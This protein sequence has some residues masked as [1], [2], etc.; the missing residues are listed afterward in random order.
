MSSPA[1]RY[2][3]DEV[4]PVSDET[5]QRLLNARAEE[6]WGFESIHFVMRD[7]SHRPSMAFVFFTRSRRA[8]GESPGRG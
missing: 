4:S 5:L 8:E 7:G 2:Q 3:V 6:G 1:P